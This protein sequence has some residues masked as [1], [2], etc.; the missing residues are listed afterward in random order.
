[1]YIAAH[2]NTIKTV[3]LT[4]LTYECSSRHS[5][6]QPNNSGQQTVPAPIAI[7]KPEI[8]QLTAFTESCE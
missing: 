5:T 4:L 3:G 8:L 6:G 1:L 7:E 2:F